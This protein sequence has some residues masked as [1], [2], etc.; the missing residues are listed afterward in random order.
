MAEEQL[1]ICC[2]AILE[3]LGKPKEHVEEM[4][5]KYVDK[6][7]ED[8]KLKVVD[9][10]YEEAKEV[11]DVQEG[12]TYY[13]AFAEIEILTEKVQ[14]LVGF[15]FDYMPSSIEIIRPDSLVFRNIDVTSMLNDLQARS[16]N[17]DSMVKQLKS[18]NDFLKRN[19][20]NLLRN[21]IQISLKINSLTLN[22]LSSATGIN[23]EELEPFLEELI[24][25]GKIEKAGERYQLKE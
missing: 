7:K 4:L 18:Q 19:T 1:E 21:V 12:I 13:T 5:K 25:E 6:I 15:C 17:T 20:K 16:H 8:D 3:V 24:R 14:H 11:D 9:E 10:Y 2:R 22:S 23:E